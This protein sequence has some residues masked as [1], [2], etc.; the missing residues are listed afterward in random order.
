M[1][2]RGYNKLAWGTPRRYDMHNNKAKR[3]DAG[4]AETCEAMLLA[5]AR[6]PRQRKNCPPARMAESKT[7]FGATPPPDRHHGWK[8]VPGRH[9][10]F[11]CACYKNP[12]FAIVVACVSVANLT[13]TSF[14]ENERKRMRMEVAVADQ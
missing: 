3:R 6:N 4:G 9:P 11:M 8:H 10:W 12:L 2:L 7:G 13:L 14:D 1:F 5:L